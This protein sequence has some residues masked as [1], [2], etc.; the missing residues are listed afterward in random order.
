[1]SIPVERA[2]SRN[3]FSRS[4]PSD[5]FSS[6]LISSPVICCIFCNSSPVLKLPYTSIMLPSALL[7]FF[8]KSVIFCT[9]PSFATNFTLLPA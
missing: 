9:E 2:V 6:R 3:R 8:M 5:A 4:L 1:M 7:A